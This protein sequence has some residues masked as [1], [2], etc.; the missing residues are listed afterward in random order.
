MSKGGNNPGGDQINVIFTVFNN[1]KRPSKRVRLSPLKSTLG[2]RVSCAGGI[3]LEVHKMKKL[4]LLV[5]A[6]AVILPLSSAMGNASTS[7]AW[8]AESVTENVDEDP[9]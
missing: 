1:N 4:P 2:C 9:D 6:M 8:C 5:I 3:R 7:S